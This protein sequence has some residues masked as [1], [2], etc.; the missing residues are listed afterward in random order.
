M[1]LLMIVLGQ[2]VVAGL[3]VFFLKKKL[4]HILIEL[5]VRH[6][7]LL[8]SQK[9][10]SVK[11]LAVITHKNLNLTDQDNI[12]RRLTKAFGS[13]L[14]LS[15]QID[16]G[17]MGGVLIKL[18]DEVIDCSLRERLQQARRAM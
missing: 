6:L 17:L 10:A 8:D 4:D 3:V 12:K 15:F 16:P 11:V 5:G 9:R 13:G 7:E 14:Q 2:L 18:G 1:F